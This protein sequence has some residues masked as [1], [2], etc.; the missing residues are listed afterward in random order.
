[1][2]IGSKGKLRKIE[3]LVKI[4][5]NSEDRRLREEKIT[6]RE[7][8]KIRKKQE[9]SSIDKERS[10]RNGKFS[11]QRNVETVVNLARKV[12]GI[13]PQSRK[14]GTKLKPQLTENKIGKIRKVFE[15]A[16]APNQVSFVNLVTNLCAVKDHL[17]T[18]IS[19]RDNARGATIGQN[20]RFGQHQEDKDQL[21]RVSQRDPRQGGGG[22]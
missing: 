3:H 21:E 14:I 2:Q 11:I 20:M 15:G 9:E 18:D 5:E 4:F 7:K 12:G 8:Q 17:N 10:G 1:M 6:S 19:V 16:A 13:S 22:S